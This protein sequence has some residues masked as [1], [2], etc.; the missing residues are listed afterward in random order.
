MSNWSQLVS[1]FV[2]F[3][4]ANLVG[5]GGGPGTIP[6]VKDQTV[7]VHHWL[8]PGGFADALA[9]AMALPG[10]VAT[11]LATYV[12]FKV[13]GVAG[14][15]SALMATLLPTAIAMVAIFRLFQVYRD[16]PYVAG[17]ITAVKPVVVVLL[18]M[19]ALDLGRT[20]FPGWAAWVVGG[21]GAVMLLFLKVNPAVVIA[22]ALAAGALFRIGPHP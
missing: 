12:G 22:L 21:A 10:P 9:F 16:S 19:V 7:N 17:A 20:A 4:Q 1:L 8:T 5:F 3:L 14:A 11:K 15:V 6:F 13:A 2:A 18:V